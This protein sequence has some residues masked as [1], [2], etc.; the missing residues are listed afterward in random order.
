MGARLEYQTAEDI[1][2]TLKHVQKEIRWNIAKEKEKNKMQ[3]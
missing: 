3:R 2:R 1:I